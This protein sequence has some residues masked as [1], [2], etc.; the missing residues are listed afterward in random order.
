MWNEDDYEH[1]LPDIDEPEDSDLDVL[2]PLAK[3]MTVVGGAMTIMAWVKPIAHYSWSL[4]SG[5]FPSF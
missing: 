2:V 1:D 5:A 3:V 4:M